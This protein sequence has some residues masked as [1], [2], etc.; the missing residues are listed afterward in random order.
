M[1]KHSYLQLLL[2]YSQLAL[3]LQT[4]LSPAQQVSHL[5]MT[6]VHHS[7]HALTCLLSHTMTWTSQL[8][9]ATRQRHHMFYG[10]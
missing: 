9:G 7:Q 5:S 4:Y 10:C 1:R 2:W 8:T 6:T 3:P